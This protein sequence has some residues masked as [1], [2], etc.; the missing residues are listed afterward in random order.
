[1]KRTFF[2]LLIACVSYHFAQ[3]QKIS[4]PDIQKMIDAYKNDPRGPYK[5]IRWFCDDG[6]IIPP[7]EKCPEPGGV[8]RAS[9]KDAVKDLADRNHVFLGQILATTD[10]SDFLDAD[11]NYSRLKQYQLENYLKKIDDGWVN[12]KA[13][14]YRGATQVEDEMEWGI[15]FLKWIFN[16]DQLL[17]ENFLLVRQTVRVLPHREDGDLSLRI[18]ANSKVLADEYARFMDLRIK[19]HGQPEPRDLNDVI[20]FKDAH[21]NKLSAKQQKLLEELIDDMRKFYAPVDINRLKAYLKQVPANAKI[22]KTLNDY[23]DAYKAEAMPQNLQSTAEVI[24]AIRKSITDVDSR[25]SRL[26]LLDLSLAL[27]EIYFKA[28]SSWSPQSIHEMAVKIQAAG[29]VA[30]GTGFLELW[31]WEALS[32][33]LKEIPSPEDVAAQQAYLAAARRLVEWGAGMTRAIYQ[34]VIELYRPFEPKASGFLD[35]LI[36]SSGLLDLGETVGTLG[37]LINKG[38]ERQNYLLGTENAS[39]ARGLNTGIVKGELVVLEETTE[40]MAVDKNKIY[41]F[42]RP[43]SDLKPVAGIATV[44]EGNLVS[45]VQLLARNLS[46][47]NAVISDQN[48]AA[49]KAFNGE[50]VFYAVSPDGQVMIKKVDQMTDRDQALFKQE[51]KK[52]S[53]ERVRVPI[54]KIDLSQTKVLNMNAVN[55]TSSG[56]VCG[57]KAANLGQL[58]AMFPKQVVEGLVIP[59]GIFR[60]HM[61]QTM[62]G[63]TVSYWQFLNQAFAEAEKMRETGKSDGEIEPFL[64]EKLNTLRAAIMEMTFFPEFV[65]DLNRQFTKIFKDDLGKVP[66]FIRSDTNMEDLPDFTGAGL[67]LT[68]FNIVDAD[69]ILRGI[70]EVWA[71]PYTERSFKWRQR[72]LL[73]PEN[74]FPSI[75]IIPSVDVDFSGVLITKGITTDEADDLTVAISRGAG[76]AVDGQAAEAYLLRADSTHQLLTPAREPSYRRLP[77]SG[78]TS[79]HVATFN[80]PIAKE[81]NLQTIREFARIVEATFPQA[82]QTEPASAYDVEFGFKDDKFWLFQIRPFVESKQNWEFVKEE[83]PTG[84]AEVN[85]GKNIMNYWWIIPILLV[86]IGG[87]IF[88]KTRQTTNDIDTQTSDIN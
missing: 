74:V 22:Y 1:M 76:G 55:A 68:L 37:D 86:L 60:A 48:F 2:M 82:T 15:N 8:Q 45:H 58:K 61:D 20:A 34:D 27:E 29:Q 84:S 14:Y 59:F 83:L 31:E 65:E 50:Q 17:E 13:Q 5:E 16:S 44:T 18:R 42:H 24:L 7:K 19:I 46:I 12:R 62:P 85:Q 49:L 3:A 40:D 54:D 38:Q 53:E 36:R 52:R 63:Q 77:V 51:Q 72:Y 35:D 26:A 73:N 23:L 79:N 70:K 75:L 41:V 25:R 69:R 56:V 11:N 71:S 88:W 47:P 9:Y 78:G 28:I 87:G 39:H 6:T 66:V 30:C 43:P 67:N 4:N 57:P 21:Q 81:K 32:K 64:L 80:H 10:Q 33:Q